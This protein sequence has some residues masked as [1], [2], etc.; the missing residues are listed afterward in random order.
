MLRLKSGY[1]QDDNGWVIAK[2]QPQADFEWRD[3]LC[4]ERS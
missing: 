2:L 3:A 4:S 1:A